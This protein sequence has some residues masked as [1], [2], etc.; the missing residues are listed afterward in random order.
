MKPVIAIYS[1][2]TPSTTFI[3]NLIKA[4]AEEGCVVYLFGYSKKRT[5]YSNP[6]IKIFTHP[7]KKWK[8]VPYVIFNQLRLMFLSNDR[9]RKL[10]Q[11]IR[12]KELPSRNRLLLWLKYLP[13]VINLPGVFHIQWARNL[14][15]WMFL[16]EVFGVKIILS[17]RG[18]QV[19]Y[20][21][22]ASVELADSYRRNFPR[23]D[24]FHAVSKDIAQM[25]AG[26]GADPSKTRVI[27][28][29]INLKLINQFDNTSVF[30]KD[31]VL[32]LISI[33]RMKWI[34][35]Y[36]LA[37]DTMKKLKDKG[38]NFHY[39]IIAGGDAEEILYQISDLK[40]NSN[41]SIIP[42]MPQQE[43]FV[44][45]ETSHLMLITSFDEGIANVA[46][47]GMA[48]GLP[49]LSSDC[50]GM[51]EVITPNRNGYLFRNRDVNDLFDKIMHFVNES[52]EQKNAIR[53]N[54]KNYVSQNHP[55][56]LLGKQMKDLY[57]K[58]INTDYPG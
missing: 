34:K 23:I 52:P 41:V 20:S 1:G 11:H 39:T 26:F 33:G 55:I 57:E 29:G 40:L 53:N 16:K 42:G 58:V 10:N 25:A 3:E 15:E 43:V 6:G 27:Y 54:A 45:M 24:G 19:K 38:V 5:Y 12:S 7:R 9:Y 22:L 31:V 18:T 56:E 30:E 28:S 2:V 14:E 36:H 13:V 21:P 51:P 17:L 8:L 46:L 48:I 37:L 32:K 44:K 50:G 4:V 49:V 47:E 35:G